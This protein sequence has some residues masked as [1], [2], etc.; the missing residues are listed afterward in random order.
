MDNGFLITLFWT[1][2][3]QFDERSLK[4]PVL[5]APGCALCPAWALRN[6]LQ[7]VPMSG[8]K[9]AFCFANGE[10]ISYSTFNNFFKAQIRKLGM[11]DKGW[12]TLLQM[13]WDRIFWLLVV[14]QREN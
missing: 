3:I 2:T 9:P 8:D 13:G 12:S 5:E 1:K 14:F 4:Y 10:L 11:S 6:M 7:L